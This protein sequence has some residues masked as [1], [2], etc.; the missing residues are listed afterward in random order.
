M[1]TK[2]Q[3]FRL[4]LASVALFAAVAVT[5]RVEAG[6]YSLQKTFWSFAGTW[7]NVVG[8]A[9]NLAAAIDVQQVTDFSLQAIFIN[10]N[11]ATAGTIDV[12]WETSV[13]GSNW[14][15][16]STNASNGR[17][18][19]WF[20]FVVTNNVKSVWITNIT[21]DSIGYWRI[22]H[23]TNSSSGNYTNV[24]V[25]GYIKPKRTNRDY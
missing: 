12:V 14:P 7:T 6:D 4:L 20:S 8:T 22:R 5:P 1:K 2:F 25:V 13:D 11:A 19:G 9:T 16:Q 18:Q 15:T 10:T 21:V 3:N 23:L 24:Q 17:A